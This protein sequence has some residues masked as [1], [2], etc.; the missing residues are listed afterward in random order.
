MAFPDKTALRKLKVEE[1]IADLHK[2]Q[3]VINTL[4]SIGLAIPPELFSSMIHTFEVLQ[5]KLDKHIKYIHEQFLP[6][7]SKFPAKKVIKKI[8]FDQEPQ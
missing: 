2:L 8:N 7:N 3:E 4:N 6:L 1:L 5:E